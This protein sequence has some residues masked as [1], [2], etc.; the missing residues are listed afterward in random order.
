MKLWI[1]CSC[2]VADLWF[3][4]REEA[5]KRIQEES[6]TLDA[7]KHQLSIVETDDDALTA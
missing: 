3:D 5:E 6:V 2:G 7:N 1:K 4:S